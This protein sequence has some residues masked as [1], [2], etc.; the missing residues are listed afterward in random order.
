MINNKKI[1]KKA[2]TPLMVTLLLVSFAV[3]VG[4]V[5]MNIGQAQV[6]EG[7]VCPVDIGFVFSSTVENGI[8]ANIE[9]LLVNIIGEEKAA[10]SP[11]SDAKMT[12]AASYVGKVNFDT[13]VNGN[14]RQVK[15]SPT[16]L[17]KGVPEICVDQA[18]VVENVPNC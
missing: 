2:I 5:V 3:A 9:E 14:I 1:N 16:V 11:L 4:V 17:L 13:S 7:A 15:I 10:A 12:R 18:L 6:E 8:N